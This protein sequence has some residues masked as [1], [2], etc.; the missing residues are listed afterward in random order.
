MWWECKV[1]DLTT[2]GVEYNGYVAKG[3]ECLCLPVL[4]ASVV[5]SPFTAQ[6]SLEPGPQQRSRQSVSALT[7]VMLDHGAMNSHASHSSA[8][9]SVPIPV[10]VVDG[11]G[12]RGVR[13]TVARRMYD[14]QLQM[15][16]SD[17]GFSQQ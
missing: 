2:K 15:Y 16:H 13:H 9:C 8:E 5:S 1:G 14:A 7:R 3:I 4:S 12:R 6:R 17:T 10:Q 11:Q